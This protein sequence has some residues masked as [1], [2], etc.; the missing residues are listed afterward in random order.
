MKSPRFSSLHFL[1][2]VA[3]LFIS[4]CDSGS[5]ART[6]LIIPGISRDSAVALLQS[7]IAG[8]P[9]MAAPDATT[10]IWRT[11]QYL[12]KGK[13]IEIIWYSAA[14]ERRTLADTV[15]NK[16]VIPIVV[17]DGKVVGTGRDAYKKAAAEYS[18]RERY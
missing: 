18:L 5:D 6:E 7:P 3:V 12:M 11:A 15:P 14:N 2:P 9:P 1:L 4:A 10:N 17:V 8:G 13:M 16:G